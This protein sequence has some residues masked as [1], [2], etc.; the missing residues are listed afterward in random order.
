MGL[1]S[2]FENISN[3]SYIEHLKLDNLKGRDPGAYNEVMNYLAERFACESNVLYQW[4]NTKADLKKLHA[5][6]IS[7]MHKVDLVKT[8]FPFENFKPHFIPV[9]GQPLVPIP[10]I[11]NLNL[12]ADLL[13][14]LQQ[15]EAIILAYEVHLQVR[16]HFTWK[17]GTIKTGSFANAFKPGSTKSNEKIEEIIRVITK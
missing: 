11:G 4:D 3:S 8:D 2:G 17:G 10:W 6:L 14:A 13:V 7:G 1:P 5:T 12:L 9:P 16:K 15:I